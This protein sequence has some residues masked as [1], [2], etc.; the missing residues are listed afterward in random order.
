MIESF[1]RRPRGLKV[2]MCSRCAEPMVWYR[3]TRSETNPDMIAHYFQCPKCSEIR[4]IKS[5]PV[6]GGPDVWVAL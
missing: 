1:D 6:Q 2:P 4:E 3:S 5:K